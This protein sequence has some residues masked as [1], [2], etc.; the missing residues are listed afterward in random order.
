MQGAF[1]LQKGGKMTTFTKEERIEQ[2]KA[3]AEGI[4]SNAEDI[5]GNAEIAVD[6]QVVIELNCQEYPTVKIERHFI[7]KK[8]ID[9]FDKY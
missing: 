1:L 8:L 4:I 2:L 5:I 9:V 7:P 6:W 3:C